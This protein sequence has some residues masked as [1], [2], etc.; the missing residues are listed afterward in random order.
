MIGHK[1]A[2]SNGLVEIGYG[3]AAG[4]R[5][6]GYATQAVAAVVAAARAD[7][8]LR[9]VAADTAV[10]N[11]ASQRVL[12]K[13]GFARRGEADRP[14][15][16]SAVALADRGLRSTR[17]RIFKKESGRAAALSDVRFLSL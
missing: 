5:G 4:R 9:G 15:R 6:R 17:D 8:A 1:S 16:R 14:A 11:V 13:N 3:I 7:P 2:P 10:A 12:I